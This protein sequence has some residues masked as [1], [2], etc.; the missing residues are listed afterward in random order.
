VRYLLH[1]L[2]SHLPS[3]ERVGVT[4]REHV[5][6]LQQLVCRHGMWMNVIW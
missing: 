4:V 5:R 6:P 2:S 3:L 1:G